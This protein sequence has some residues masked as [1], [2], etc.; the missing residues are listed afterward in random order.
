MRRE[1]RDYMIKSVGYALDIL[2]QFT[3]EAGNL[4]G[5][6]L[7]GRLKINKK[8]VDRLLATLEERRYLLRERHT[9]RYRLGEM[10]VELS[11]AFLRH[12]DLRRTV[13][14]ALERLRLLSGETCF[15]TKPERDFVVYREVLEGGQAVR[16]TVNRG[17]RAALHRSVA[18]KA[19]LAFSRQAPRESAQARSTAERRVL[20]GVAAPVV[21]DGQLS[22]ISM[23]GYAL[24]REEQ[25]QGVGS[26]VAPVR[27]HAGEVVA[28]IGCMVPLSRFQRERRSRELI[29]AVVR[30]ADDVSRGMGYDG[31]V[32]ELHGSLFLE[33]RRGSSRKVPPRNKMPGGTEDGIFR[34]AG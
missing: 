30:A 14:P 29:P 17:S 34:A 3:T 27:N 8:C 24:G 20:P 19:L 32:V 5:D 33:S 10:N 12:L 6:F 23:Q 18:G 26:V 1:K 9:G 2:E 4:D 25:H 11:Q 15:M 16:V 7:S 21:L 31:A 13:L 22:R 28:A